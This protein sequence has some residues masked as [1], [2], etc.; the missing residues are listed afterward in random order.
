MIMMMMTTC[1]G[2]VRCEKFITHQLTG[3]LVVTLTQSS[4]AQPALTS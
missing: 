1:G 3:L 2:S 4:E